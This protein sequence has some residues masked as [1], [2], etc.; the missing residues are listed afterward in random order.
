MS[1]GYRISAG[2]TVASSISFPLFNGHPFPGVP[3]EDGG[4]GHFFRFPFLSRGSFPSSFRASPPNTIWFIS[5]ITSGGK[6]F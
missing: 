1:L 2:T 4:G 5:F 6:R 3:P